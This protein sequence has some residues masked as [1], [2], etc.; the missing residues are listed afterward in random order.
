[1]D[2]RYFDARIC[3]TALAAVAILAF[4]RVRPTLR[5]AMSIMLA[6]I[7]VATFGLVAV[8]PFPA[9]QAYTFRD[10]FGASSS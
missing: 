6:W 8:A 5:S 10:R 7:S 1:M 4:A 9:G 2:T 3:F